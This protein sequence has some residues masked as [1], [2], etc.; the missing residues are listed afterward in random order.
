[1]ILLYYVIQSLNISDTVGYLQHLLGTSTRA[2]EA[3][4]VSEVSEVSETV[5]RRVEAAVDACSVQSGC[6]VIGQAFCQE[7][8]D[9][10]YLI[11]LVDVVLLALSDHF[12]TRL[13]SGLWRG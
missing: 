9:R 5:D 2:S 8:G 6:K 10:R 4:E 12:T 7:L 3:R 1:M 11:K 13:L